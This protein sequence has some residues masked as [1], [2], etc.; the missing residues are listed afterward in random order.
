MLS[1]ALTDAITWAVEHTPH[2]R[3]TMKGSL[4]ASIPLTYFL[5]Y[6]RSFSG[7]STSIENP[8]VVG[9]FLVI[10]YLMLAIGAMFY[11]IHHSKM[12]GILLKMS[13]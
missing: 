4:S 1:I 6:F 13:E 12:T 8:L 7:F 11:A 10:I 9:Y 5:E 3:E 2:I